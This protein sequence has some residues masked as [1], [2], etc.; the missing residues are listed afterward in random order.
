MDEITDAAAFQRLCRAGRGYIYIDSPQEGAAGWQHNILHAARCP[1][2][3][4]TDVT[5][6]CTRYYAAAVQVATAWLTAYRPGAWTPCG[7]CE[8][9]RP[10]DGR[11]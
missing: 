11:P 9:S 5:T 2:L 1:L 4:R 8:P 10:A 6:L 3:Q 7:I